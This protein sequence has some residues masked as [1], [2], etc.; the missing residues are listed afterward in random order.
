MLSGVALYAFS[1][2]LLPWL[3]PFLIAWAVAAALEP[4]V[5]RLCRSGVSRGVA[6]GISTLGFFAAL[7]SLLWLVGARLLREI[8]ELIPRL[9][10]MLSAVSD[11]LRQWQ[12][13]LDRWI[14]RAPDS[15]SAILDSA[16]SGVTENLSRLPGALTG[17]LLGWVS[18]FASAAPSVLLFSV[19]A[20]I[21][22]YFIS[23]CY[24]Q[25]LH[26]AARLLP[27]RFL[28]RARLLR[29]DLRRTLGRWLKAQGLMTLIVW[30]LLFCCWVCVTRCCWRC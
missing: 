2:W 7:L 8:G 12:A 18:N 10:E 30:R 3:W 22:T 4:V 25:L 20:V 9:P 6:A 1:R 11:T 5:T 26:G 15:L 24:P 27:D 23:A 17:R 21:G 16:V 29:R 14:E 28:F 19:T 13:T